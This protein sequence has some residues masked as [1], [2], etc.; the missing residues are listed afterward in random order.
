M[1]LWEMIRMAMENIWANRLRSALTVLGIII[2]V[3]SVI[4]VV[5][6]GQGGQ[7]RIL[8]EMEGIGTN[9]FVV[10]IG[11]TED[12]Y[13]KYRIT[14]EDCRAI[15]ESVESIEALSPLVYGYTVVEGSP[16]KQSAYVYGV[17]SDYNQIQNIKMAAG[18][19]FSSIDNSVARRVVVIN[20]RLAEELFGSARMAVGKKIK[21][22]QVSVVVC[23]VAESGSG[24]FGPESPM[25][26][27]PIKLHFQLFDSED[28]INEIYGSAAHK[29]L[30][31]E[32]A[33]KAIRVLEVRHQVKDSK[34]YQFVTMSQQMDAVDQVLAIITMI[35]GAIAGIS[36]LVGGIGIMNIML[37]SITERTREIG[38]RMAVGAK[39][40]DIMRQ[41][42]LESVVLSVTGGLIGVFL[43]VGVSVIVCM[44]MDIPVV[45]S[46]GTIILALLFSITVGV[47]F[48]IYPANRAA[49]QDPIEALRYE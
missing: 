46:F 39:R 47:F 36:L 49:K 17:D 26:Y 38:V 18:R 30:V 21:V 23:G 16:R 12:D 44:A 5:T 28:R 11:T 24:M 29:D 6:I 45:I 34:A 33:R 15:K 43:G 10:Y 4:L 2:G 1:N 8:N 37:V 42:L 14:L 13:E 31:E 35:I 19:F 40:E 3:M 22:K 48:G 32:S 27:M 7:A 25:V 20:Q 9:L 41:F